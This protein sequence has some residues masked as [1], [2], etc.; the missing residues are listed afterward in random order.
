MSNPTPNNER[1]ERIALWLDVDDLRWLAH[2]LAEGPG[3]ALQSADLERAARIRFW[4]L[5]TLRKS[6]HSSGPGT[7]EEDAGQEKTG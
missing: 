4:V 1:S 3:A 7:G 6:G 2:Y 5:A